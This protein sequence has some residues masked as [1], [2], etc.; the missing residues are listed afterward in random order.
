M[1][2]IVDGRFVSDSVDDLLDVMVADLE[3]V[4]GEPLPP[5]ESS[6]VRSLYRPMA[7]QF[8]ELQNQVGLVLDSAQIDHATE[9]ALDY[10]TALIGVPRRK[11]VSA[12][13][14]VTFSRDSAAAQDYVIPK[15]IEVQTDGNDP[16]VFQTTSQ[17]TLATGTT[18]V[19]APVKAKVP[20]ALGNVASDTITVIRSSLSGA[21]DVNNATSTN[22][23]RNKETDD[24]LRE[25]AKDNLANGARASAAGLISAIRGIPEVISVSIFVND[26]SV[27]NSDGLASHSFEL[28]IEHDG[29]SGV[30]DKIAQAILETKAAG[31]GSSGGVYGTASSGLG[32]LI[33]GQ[34]FTI[35]FSEPTPVQ[36][37]V[38]MDLRVTEDYE[39]D[40]AVRNEIVK[41]IGGIRTTG[42]PENGRLSVGRDVIYGTVEYAI[43]TVNGVYDINSLTIGTTASPTGTANITVALAEK[44]TT[45]GT[46]GSLTLTTTLVTP[47]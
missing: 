46:D 16:V 43:R 22:G 3:A 17:V 27:A 40:D 32:V 24:E 1:A 41:Y 13:G 30:E 8:V 2:S 47:E 33:N 38:D 25:R 18:S 15:G 23:G 4:R 10:L 35:S 11:A 6:I 31:A 19:N 39:G 20:G 29:S 44:A 45:D 21:T 42:N 5:E 36:I 34:E 26:D 7:T 12:T 37:Y 14:E 9:Q 28:V